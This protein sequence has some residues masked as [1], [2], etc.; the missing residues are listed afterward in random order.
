MLRRWFPARGQPR[1]HEVDHFDGV[2]R[3]AKTHQNDRIRQSCC[4]HSSDT[5]TTPW[6]RWIPYLKTPSETARHL[7]MVRFGSVHWLCQTLDQTVGSV[8]NGQVLV[9]KWSKP[10]TGPKYKLTGQKRT[11]YSLIEWKRTGIEE[12]QSNE[13]VTAAVMRN[14]NCSWSAFKILADRGPMLRTAETSPFH[15]L[16]YN[17]L[18][19]NIFQLL[20]G[21]LLKCI[22]FL[23][24]KNVSDRPFD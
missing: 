19:P 16:P 15:Y 18:N 2:F 14:H 9:L 24:L 1:Q 5:L 10:W 22:R 17:Y 3:F 7:G 6:L 11:F 13:A 12:E 23:T 8:Q 20:V 21:H 4:V